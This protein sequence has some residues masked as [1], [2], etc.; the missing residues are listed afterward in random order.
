MRTRAAIILA[1]LA[2]LAAGA[3]GAAPYPNSG[4]ITGVSWDTA[5]YRF[6]GAGGDLWP[7]TA[8]ADGKVY[9]AWG[10]GTVTYPVKVSYGVAS[11]AGGPSAALRR[12]GLGTPGGQ[13]R[14]LIPLP[15]VAGAPVAGPH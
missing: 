9:T 6:A 8:G 7:V 11:V 5:T 1:A 3:A 12:G 4:L 10:D 2:S 14:K 13:A 15:D